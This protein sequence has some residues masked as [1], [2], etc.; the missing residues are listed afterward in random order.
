MNIKPITKVRN[1]IEVLK[2]EIE[3]KHL[4]IKNGGND[5][6]GV[7]KHQELLGYMEMHLKGLLV[8]EKELAL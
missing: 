2:G 5:W 1:Q 6:G 4:M 3:R 7:E 8:K